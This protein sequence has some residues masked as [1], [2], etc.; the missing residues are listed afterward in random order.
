MRVPDLHVFRHALARLS[1][2]G[3]APQPSSRV[4]IVPTVGAARQLRQT[5]GEGGP[6]R[7]VTREEF[8]AL[9]HEQLDDPPARLTAYD[10][11]VMVQSAARD[12]SADVGL[13][14]GWRLRPGLI[15]EILRFY[16]QLRRQARNVGRFEALLDE[17]LSRDAEH[18]RGAERMLAQT[19]FLAATFR[20][21]ED[22][23]RASGACDEH[24]L[25]ERLVAEPS[26]RPVATHRRDDRGLDCRPARV[27][28]GRLR[29]DHSVAWC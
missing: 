2:A 24:V 3:D 8:Y 20:G 17:T 25:R 28:P 10:R 9:L 29:S 16:D 4:V 27:L 22:R 13:A 6:R 11:D 21:Y 18:D 15:A 12:A 5:V 1:L 23:V 7:L 26:S 14:A 19:R